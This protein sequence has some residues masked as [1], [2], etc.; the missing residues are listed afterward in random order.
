[1]PHRG[2]IRHSLRKQDLSNKN[3]GATDH[4]F[5]GISGLSVGESLVCSGTYDQ[6]KA[7]TSKRPSLLRDCFSAL[8]Q[9]P[10]HQ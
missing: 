9:S 2:N 1:M 3:G 8:S 6:L 4:S 10:I 7:A 5:S